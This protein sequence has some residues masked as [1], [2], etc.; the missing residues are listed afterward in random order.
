MCY[1]CNTCSCMHMH[2]DA[3]ATLISAGGRLSSATNV[4]MR[5]ICDINGQANAR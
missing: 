5:P 1:M 2:V 4:C 3:A